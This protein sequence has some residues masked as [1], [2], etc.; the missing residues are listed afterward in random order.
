MTAH[1]RST[2]GELWSLLIEHSALRS[3]RDN[4]PTRELLNIYNQKKACTN[5]SRRLMEITPPGR[6]HHGRD[7]GQPT[8][9][10]DLASWL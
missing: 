7:N 4:Q 8:R 3:K 5:E 6:I 2:H 9:Q 10:N 1:Q